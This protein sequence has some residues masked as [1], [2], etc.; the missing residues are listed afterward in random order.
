MLD[1][2]G[3]DAALSP[4]TAT[5]N[6]VLRF[7]RGDVAQVATFLLGEVE[8]LEFELHGDSNAD[9]EAICDLQLPRDVLITAIVRDG[10][11]Q[12]ARGRTT[13]RK[14]DHVIVVAEPES[15]DTVAR[16]LG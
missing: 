8:M 10:R 1:Q 13:L 7:V 12:I 4:R 15:V 2:V 3:V 14:G 16:V 5:A 9:S 6:G 11:S